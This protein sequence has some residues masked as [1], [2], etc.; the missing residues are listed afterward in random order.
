[1]GP[2]HALLLTSIRFQPR[3]DSYSAEEQFCAD[4]GR[5]LSFAREWREKGASGFP[6]PWWPYPDSRRHS[7]A[8]E[9]HAHRLSGANTNIISLS[10]PPPRLQKRPFP[11]KASVDSVKTEANALL[12]L[13]TVHP[14]QEQQR[15]LEAEKLAKALP[16]EEWATID[17]FSDPQPRA[18][19]LAKQAP[20]LQIR[21]AISRRSQ[22]REKKR[23]QEQ[24]PI[25]TCYSSFDE[26]TFGKRS[27]TESNPRRES[28]LT[29]NLKAENTKCQTWVACLKLDRVI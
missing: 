25:Q 12:P 18:A 2:E 4:L 11:R 21:L 23:I 3:C 7:S 10:M 20:H 1:M 27:S 13:T 5:R 19:S 9:I 6:Q 17:S 8:Q 24:Q 15:S 26:E 28:L 16:A 22:A 14:Y 29:L